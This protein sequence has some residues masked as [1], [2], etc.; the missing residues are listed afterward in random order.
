MD[1][2]SFLTTSATSVLVF[3]WPIAFAS[4]AHIWPGE[5][6]PFLHSTTTIDPGLS[7]R[8][9]K[10]IVATQEHIFPSDMSAALPSPGARD[11]NAKAF[12]YAVLSDAHRDK[13]D[14][15]RV[16]SG[17]IAL[18][19]LCVDKYKKNFDQLDATQK[20][21]MLRTFENMPGGTSWIMTILGYVFEALL[22]DPVYGGNP[23]GIGWQWLE[24]QPGFPRPSTKDRYFL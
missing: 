24:H 22:T 1:R 19:K 21:T 13:E 20:E 23:N 7:R 3:T 11:V 4:S 14:R 17:V 9:W 18:Q 2:R 5:T 15:E 10:A 16:K 8:Q 12:L 6:P